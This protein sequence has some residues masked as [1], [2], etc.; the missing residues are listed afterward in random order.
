MVKTQSID[1]RPAFFGPVF[2]LSLLTVTLLLYPLSLAAQTKPET[3]RVTTGTLTCTL[4]P[5][6]MDQTSEPR[7][8]SCVF[9]QVSQQTTNFTGTFKQPGDAAL[10]ADRLVLVWTVLAPSAEI[11]PAAL[12]GR[13]VSAENADAEEP[14][15]RLIG[16]ADAAIELQPLV[17]IPDSTPEDTLLVL[18]LDLT[19]LRA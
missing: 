19:Y 8:L 16:G 6:D 17:D 9:D 18:E 7:G 3:S 15:G 13:Y 4:E 14:D 12:E 10:T 5:G 1:I 11:D 2:L